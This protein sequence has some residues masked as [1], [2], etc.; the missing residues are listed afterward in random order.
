MKQRILPVFFLATILLALTTVGMV[1][2]GAQ[3]YS[4]SVAQLKTTF[5]NALEF[6][7]AAQLR[8]FAAQIAAQ[9]KQLD[10]LEATATALDA[11]ASNLEP[12]RSRAAVATSEWQAAQTRSTAA[13][14]A[15]ERGVRAWQAEAL[16]FE[17]EHGDYL[18]KWG[19]PRTGGERTAPAGQ[20]AIFNRGLAALQERE[21]RILA[22]REVFV[23][24]K[25][26]VDAL[27][28]LK[29][30]KE[31][32]MQTA[33]RDSTA[34]QTALSTRTA[35]FSTLRASAEAAITGRST[36][37]GALTPFPNG[38][39]KPT[40]LTPYVPRVPGANINALDQ[41]RANAEK[42]DSYFR[43]CFEESGCSAGPQVNGGPQILVPPAVAESLLRNPLYKDAKAAQALTAQR[44]ESAT[45][46]LRTIQ[47]DR[48]A[49]REQLEVATKAYTKAS[50]DDVIAAFRVKEFGDGSKQDEIHEVIVVVP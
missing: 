32:A 1:R 20:G 45:V 38:V 15:L 35:E 42:K 28:A 18:E 4:A 34:L 24:E 11:A 19:L 29:E 50:S 47:R 30:Q 36:T 25:A 13:Q 3:N 39:A 9:W 46:E 6:M 23:R 37:A 5:R 7:S 17:R 41:A 44:R 8:T 21:S 14:Q 40:D 49:T 22:R 27:K 33:D 2:L 12:A 31:R 16:Q 43:D 48:N 26:Q 10:D